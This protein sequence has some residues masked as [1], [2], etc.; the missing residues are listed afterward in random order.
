M[1]V[2]LLTENRF[3]E[4]MHLFKFARNISVKQEPQFYPYN[5]IMNYVPGKVTLQ[6]DGVD[7]EI[8]AT[9]VLL[10]IDEVEELRKKVKASRAEI[11]Q[12]VIEKISGIYEQP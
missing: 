1:S 2:E 6:I 5:G 3:R 4:L 10:L 7:S 11:L 8:V 9:N 12:E